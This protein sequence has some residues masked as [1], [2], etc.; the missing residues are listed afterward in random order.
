METV[1]MGE[2]NLS[3]QTEIKKEQQSAQKLNFKN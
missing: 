3:M 1:L 2:L